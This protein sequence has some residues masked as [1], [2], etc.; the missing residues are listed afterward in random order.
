M[1]LITDE[2][3]LLE[4]LFWEEEQRDDDG[5]ITAI[6]GLYEAARLEA[7]HRIKEPDTLAKVIKYTEQA[8]Y[9][10]LA[11]IEK[12]S[13]PADLATAVRIW[14]EFDKEDILTA[15]LTRLEELGET[16]LLRELV[17][18]EDVPDKLFQAA[19]QA[20]NDQ[21]I[22]FALLDLEMA[23]ST[24]FIDQ[25]LLRRLEDVNKLLE[26]FNTLR[27][28]K[29]ERHASYVANRLVELDAGDRISD[30]QILRWIV[31]NEFAHSHKAATYARLRLAKLEGEEA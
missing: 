17:L 13:D 8:E 26:R 29:E 10:V 6:Y 31:N 23:R 22:L 7:V 4:L 5:D 11:A 28:A 15:L 14:S 16:D 21:D 3:I 20:V 24:R 2:L 9:V 30:P 27:S 19:C 18:G 12:V 1:Q 25:E